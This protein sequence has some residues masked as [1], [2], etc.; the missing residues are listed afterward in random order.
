M[1]LAM[2]DH[3]LAISGIPAGLQNELGS[4]GGNFLQRPEQADFDEVRQRKHKEEERQGR[5]QPAN[6]PNSPQQESGAEQVNDEGKS[7]NPLAALVGGANGEEQR[8]HD[9]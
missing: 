5:P 4:H 1:V 8:A 6:R 2:E 7:L 3:A 9:D